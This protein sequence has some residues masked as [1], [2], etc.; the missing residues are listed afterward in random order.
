MSEVFNAFQKNKNKCF[1]NNSPHETGRFFI[2]IFRSMW[3]FNPSILPMIGA[4]GGLCCTSVH[5]SKFHS[6]LC[7]E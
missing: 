1:N 5:C 4:E 6:F 7:N 2:A 3:W